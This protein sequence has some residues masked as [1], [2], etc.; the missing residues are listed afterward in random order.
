MRKLMYNEIEE[1]VMCEGK[2]FMFDNEG[3]PVFTKI[4]ENWLLS[5]T[6]APVPTAFCKHDTARMVDTHELFVFDGVVWEKIN[7]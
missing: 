5:N 2:D 6:T 7:I 4:A 1:D 3:I